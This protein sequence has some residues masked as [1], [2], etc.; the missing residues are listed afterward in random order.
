MGQG[1]DGGEIKD[2]PRKLITATLLK[3]K[4][5]EVRLY[6]A[7]CLSDVL[8]IFAPEDP[9]QDDLVLKGVYVAFL[10]ALAHLKDPSKSAFECAHALLQNIAAIGLCVPMLDLEY[11][12][13]DA[14]VPRLFSTLFDAT[15][16]SNASLVEEDVTKVLAIM[17]EEDE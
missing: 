7:L 15:N 11:E 6:A 17:I 9:Y 2:L 1:E 13:S 12:G 16:P 8:R 5:K 4:E 14:S 10:D 3:H